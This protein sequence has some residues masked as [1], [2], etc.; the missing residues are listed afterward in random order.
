M[1]DIYRTTKTEARA[2]RQRKAPWAEAEPRDGAGK[3][4]VG[5]EQ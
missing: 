1:L 3:I 4:S 2:S 5:P